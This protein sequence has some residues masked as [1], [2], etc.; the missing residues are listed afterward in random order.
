MEHFSFEKNQLGFG[1][2]RVSGDTDGQTV[3]NLTV[4]NL[5]VKPVLEYKTGNQIVP[6]LP[7]QKIDALEW[8][9]VHRYVDPNKKFWADKY[10]KP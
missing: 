4:E 3:E 5:D 6:E 8:E 1:T 7:P 2:I 9:L 10:R